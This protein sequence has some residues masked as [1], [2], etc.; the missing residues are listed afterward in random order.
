M[1]KKRLVL[2]L[3]TILTIA[4]FAFLAIGSAT[5]TTPVPRADVTDTEG[6]ILS[7][8][9]SSTGTVHG[10][11][12]VASVRPYEVLGLV[13]ATSVTEF[14]ENGLEVSSQEGIVTML[15]REAQKL[16]G[17]DI[18]NLRVD[19]NVTNR[20]YTTTQTRTEAGGT[21][22]REVTV[23]RKTVTY[24]ASALAIKY[25]DHA[26]AVEYLQTQWENSRN[27]APAPGNNFVPERATVEGRL[28]PW[29]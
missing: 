28:L 19:E 12:P 9:T 10:I 29:R 23:N 13:F 25:M 27:D 14:D 5:T 20:Q 8:V 26:S 17:D 24:T 18:I 16:G 2:H 6:T 22:T 7:S 3:V 15:L 21:T 11:R 4:I 1:M